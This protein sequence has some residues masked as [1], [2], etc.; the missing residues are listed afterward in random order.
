MVG[1]IIAGLGQDKV[2]FST[3]EWWALATP[4][5]EDRLQYV[6]RPIKSIRVIDG[7]LE[8]IIDKERKLYLHWKDEHGRTTGPQF[9][10]PGKIRC[11]DR[12]S[13]DPFWE[14]FERC[15]DIAERLEDGEEIG[16]DE[17]KE[18]ESLGRQFEQ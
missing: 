12:S 3:G 5:D 17:V 10:I 13:S 14:F 1:K 6:G 9:P 8:L 16:S 15:L 11:W 4:F 2:I 7:R 18:L